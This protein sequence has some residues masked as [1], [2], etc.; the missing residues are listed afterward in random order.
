MSVK[1]QFSSLSKLYT[2]YEKVPESILDETDADSYFYHNILDFALIDIRIARVS[3][4]SN[5]KV[6]AFK[7]FQFCKLKIQ[8]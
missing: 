8:Q 5:K 1:K 4:G 6:F 3:K 2:L 7:I